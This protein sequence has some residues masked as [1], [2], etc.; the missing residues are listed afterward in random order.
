MEKYQ[1]SFLFSILE[2]SHNKAN[3]VR[4]RWS[5][6]SLTLAAYLRR[7]VPSE[8]SSTL[9]YSNFRKDFVF[10]SGLCR[11]RLASDLGEWL[12]L[13]QQRLEQ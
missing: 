4:S 7:Y 6:D 13:K 3:K 2:H 10:V 12:Y 5:P 9:K 8:L 1:K 11:S